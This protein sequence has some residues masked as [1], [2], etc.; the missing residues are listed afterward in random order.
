MSVPT[1]IVGTGRCGSTMLSNMLREHP[2]VLSLSEY[3]TVA[4]DRPHG[5]AETDSMQA[6]DGQQFWSIVAGRTPLFD[7]AF[8]HGVTFKEALYPYNSPDARYS[9]QTG[10]P[11][12]LLITLPHLSQDY[13]ALF[14][15]LRDEVAT[16]PSATPGEHYRHL[17]SRL[18]ARFDKRTWIER[19]GGSLT[20]VDR[21]LALFPDARF[22]HIVR[23]G[24]DASMSMQEQHIFRLFLILNAL[25]QSLGVDPLTS[26]DRTQL[27]RVPETMRPFLPEHFDIEAFRAFRFPLPVCGELWTQQ[28][29]HG[30]KVIHALPADR[31]LALRYED[32]LTD[33]KRQLDILAGFVGEEFIDV[34]WSARSAAT[35]RPP[36]STWRDLPED[37]ACALTEA[38]RPGFEQL[39]A[40]GVNYDV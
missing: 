18:A 4:T 21:L 24:R 40:A 15:T 2:H 19:S 14:D 11:A 25:E 7:F 28:I 26:R 17:F 10:V 13:E 23:D 31:L 8:R 9:A 6:I 34:D 33:P 1:F 27:D 29:N 35:V 38:C 32:I 39:R 22:V 37:E 36:R 20:M 12:I 3:F 16:W 5:K 30:M